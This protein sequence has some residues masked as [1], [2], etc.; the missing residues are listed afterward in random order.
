MRYLSHPPPSSATPTIPSSF[1]SLALSRLVSSAFAVTIRYLDPKSKE[2]VTQ[3]EIP[4]GFPPPQPAHIEKQ[5]QY[6]EHPRVGAVLS[7]LGGANRDPRLNQSNNNTAVGGDGRKG[8]ERKKGGSPERGGGD[9]DSSGSTSQRRRTSPTLTWG[10]DQIATFDK[11]EAPRGIL[12]VK[13]SA[14]GG[15]GGGGGGRRKQ[16]RTDSAEVTRL[17]AELAAKAKEVEA[18]KQKVTKIQQFAQKVSQE[19]EGKL[20]AERSARRRA[21]QEAEKER[22]FSSS[23]KKRRVGGAATDVSKG[24]PAFQSGNT[25]LHQLAQRHEKWPLGAIAELIHNAS[26]AGATTVRITQHGDTR[27]L[28][29]LRI[30]DNGSGI[31][32]GKPKSIGEVATGMH[33][34]MQIGADQKY[35]GSSKDGKV[36]GYG[37]GA[38]IGMMAIAHSAVIFTLGESESEDGAK[39]ETVSVALISNHPFESRGQPYILKFVTLHTHNSKPVK[40]ISTQQDK[41]ALFEQIRGLDSSLDEHFLQ[42]WQGILEERDEGFGTTVFLIGQRPPTH[43]DRLGR[44]DRRN[45]HPLPAVRRPAL[46]GSTGQHG[47]ARHPCSVFIHAYS[48]A[49]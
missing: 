32:H 46:R 13:S 12:V 35:G 21:E 1:P 24:A 30:D 43:P 38:K 41:A 10:Q 9:G 29:N 44:L 15:G 28:N 19:K 17:K 47:T 6:P 31:G 26:D 18:E 39:V 8:K 45:P 27:S 48:R 5:V 20:I 11:T 40:G 2:F 33:K 3:Y 22:K 49:Q 23:I 7:R 14:G 37:V 25:L 4:T 42:R 34:L 16:L 36:G